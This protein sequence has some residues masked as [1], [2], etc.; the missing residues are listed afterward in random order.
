MEFS[1]DAYIKARRI[2]LT[3]MLEAFYDLFTEI[4]ANAYHSDP[5]NRCVEYLHFIQVAK[6]G[7]CTL[8]TDFDSQIHE[9]L[10]QYADEKQSAF[11]HEVAQIL[12]RLNQMEAEHDAPGLFLQATTRNGHGYEFNVEALARI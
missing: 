11:Y 8:P 12:S 3:E 5:K 7:E 9:H 10:Y 6:N 4:Q 2:N 1:E